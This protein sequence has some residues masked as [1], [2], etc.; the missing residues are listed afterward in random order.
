MAFQNTS[1]KFALFIEQRVTRDKLTYI[2]AIIEFC[3]LH[4][5]EPQLI[6]PFINDKM[7]SR[8]A[9]EAQDLHLIEKSAQLP[10][11]L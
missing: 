6:V 3:S 9:E 4:H 2:D 1:E 7:K 8:I 11:I 5:I 10:F